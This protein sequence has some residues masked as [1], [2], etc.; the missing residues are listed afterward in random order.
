MSKKNTCRIWAS[1]G[2]ISNA[3]TV[4]RY[5]DPESGTVNLSSTVS[6]FFVSARNLESLLGCQRGR[7]GLRCCHLLP[8]GTGSPLVI[9]SASGGIS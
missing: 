7:A 1:S 5:P 2:S 8:P 6:A 9:V 4:E 3:A